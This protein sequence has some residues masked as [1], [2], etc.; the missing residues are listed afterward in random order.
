MLAQF[1]QDSITIIETFQCRI[2]IVY[3]VL[4]EY[5]ISGNLFQI[6]LHGVH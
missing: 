4:S 1:K 3:I 5:Q 6:H 2:V